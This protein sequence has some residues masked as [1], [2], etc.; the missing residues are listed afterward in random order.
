MT[1]TASPVLEE[2]LC[3]LPS[4]YFVMPI[5]PPDPFP[6]LPQSRYS[7][8]CPGEGWAPHDPQKLKE[9]A[10]LMDAPSPP[11]PAPNAGA[12][13]TMPSGYVYFGQ[14]VDHDLTRNNTLLANA[15]PQ[16]GATANCR[17]AALDLEVLYGNGPVASSALYAD[18]E[19]L[20]LGEAEAYTETVFPYHSYAASQNDLYR[21]GSGKAVVVD[22]RSDENVII[23]Q[24]H[25]LWI[26]L[27]NRLLDLAQEQEE[28]LT[29][30][31]EG[32]LFAQVRQL[33]VWLYQWIIVHDFLPSFIRNDVL[34][35]V[36]LR[37]NLQLYRVVGPLSR[38]PFS[39]P[40]EFTVA[41]YRFGHS[42]VR[43]EYTL[44]KGRSVSTPELL[45]M[46]NKGGGITSGL[47]ADFVIDWS[48]F[49]EEKTF[50][51]RGE[52]IDTFIASALS[53][54]P[55]TILPQTTLLRG[56]AMHLPSGEEFAKHFNW[57][58][59]AAVDIPASVGPAQVLFQDT[60]F[61]GRTP[62]WYYLLRESAVAAVFEPGPRDDS[63]LL[64]KLG[65]AGS[66]IVA[67]V[68][69]QVLMADGNSIFH[70][71]RHWQPPSC[72]IGPSRT[73][74]KL[75]SLLALARLTEA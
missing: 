74:E 41:A 43:D 68:F 50:A 25:V 19:K 49:L 46:T 23:A 4:L 64:Q 39:L 65:L 35:D 33:V 13:L 12:R 61:R 37:R 72:V 5:D 60:S 3:H 15:K 6:E 62:L 28:L 51:N 8:L 63:F 27:H 22:S 30:L 11:D 69:Y 38:T 54:I 55:G 20:R 45:M 16:A 26:K 70:S 21:D 58:V 31:P 47:R 67:E 73:P 44:A 24:M 59:L 10:E 36:F 42:M 34:L 53:R 18:G 40:I 2:T 32:S 52:R 66:R 57:P 56:S 1:K 9:L 17:R 29:G 7:R 71:G 14:F 48:L 75:S